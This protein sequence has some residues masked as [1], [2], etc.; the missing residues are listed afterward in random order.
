MNITQRLV[1]LASGSQLILIALITVLVYVALGQFR[2]IDLGN[3]RENQIA[4]TEQTVDEQ[5]D[6][7]MSIVTYYGNQALRD[8]DSVQAYQLRAI[9]M[10]GAIRWGSSRNTDGYFY[11][12]TDEGD[13]VTPALIVGD[14]LEDD[15]L[16]RVDI[17]GFPYVKRVIETA[18]AG[19]DTAVLYKRRL[20][21]DDSTQ[22]Q[23]LVKARHYIPW[24]WVVGTGAYI[25]TID[26]E[27]TEQ[28]NRSRTNDIDLI[29]NIFGLALLTLI[30]AAGIV[31]QRTRSVMKPLKSISDS[32]ADIAKGDADLTRQLQVTSEDEIGGLAKNL[33]GLLEKLR[34][35]I[36]Q[37]KEDAEAVSGQGT[38]V[39]NYTDAISHDA[40]VMK[41]RT[42]EVAAS[43][44]AAKS[45]VSSVAASVQQID[46]SAQ[47]VA[48]LSE[49]IMNNFFTV[50]AST[51]EMNSNLRML[52]V[53]SQGMN[54]DVGSV[55]I[56]LKEINSSLSEVMGT[57]AQ[58]SEKIT[59]T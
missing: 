17:A 32:I 27:L 56:A 42:D 54:V 24:H 22:T 53:A 33:N 11:V 41:L 52:S 44:D 4:M 30:V 14:K 38:R 28:A 46:S 34:G 13:T 31:Y 10:L 29:E 7:A 9:H 15:R 45:N 20:S 5:I 36:S 3:S 21:A 59:G 50:Q 26:E 55:A 57:V 39:N 35:L 2:E 12:F 58:T 49:G 8:P 6:V 1:L 19:S 43:V 23:K 16:D 25:R 40:K 47:N 51:E 18:R 37:I 48:R